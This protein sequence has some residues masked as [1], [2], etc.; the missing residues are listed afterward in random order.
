MGP[1]QAR[2]DAVAA[3]GELLPNGDFEFLGVNRGPIDSAATATYVFGI[4]RSGKL[5]PGPF[6]NRPHIRFDAL[7]VV[8]IAPGKAPTA[9]VVDL[10][11]GKNSLMPSS[12]VRVFGNTVQVIVPGPMLPPTGLEPAHYRFN[13]WPDEGMP[14]PQ[15]IASFVPELNNAPVG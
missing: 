15:R 9:S 11:S 10:A 4:D 13:Y 8:R 14:V 3:A 2:L 7:V 12:C 6:P 5:P 1:K